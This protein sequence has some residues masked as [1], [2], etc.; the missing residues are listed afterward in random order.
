MAHVHI[1]LNVPDRVSAQL[2]YMPL[3]WVKRC[4][5]GRYAANT[6]Q[7]HKIGLSAILDANAW[8]YEAALM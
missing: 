7:S 6:L 2:A 5:N 3:K 1:L 8:V 4:L